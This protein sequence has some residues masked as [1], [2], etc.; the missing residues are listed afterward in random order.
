MALVHEPIEDRVRQRRLPEV[1]VPLIDRQ[2]ADDH[3]GLGFDSIV[4]DL[5]QMRPILRRGRRQP[6]VIERDQVGLGGLAQERRV[7]ALGMC[8]PRSSSSRGSRQYR[9]DRPCRQACRASAQNSQLLPVPVLPVSASP[10]PRWIQSPVASV[11]IR[12]LSSSRT[13]R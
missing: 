13:G 12:R 2:L 8:D 11:A 5:E 10:W 6:P 9:T 4:E 1:R 7:A 3:G